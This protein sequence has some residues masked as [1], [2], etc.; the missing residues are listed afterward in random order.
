MF[1]VRKKVKMKNLFLILCSIFI[2]FIQI[3]LINA[4]VLVGNTS[5]NLAGMYGASA[6]LTGWVNLS[7][8]NRADA[9][10]E[11]VMGQNKFNSTLKQLHDEFQ[12]KYTCEPS[13]CNEV[14]SA[15]FEYTSK[16]INLSIA[17]DTYLGLYLN[18]IVERINEVSFSI[19]S[20]NQPGCKTPLSIDFAAD[21]SYDFDINKYNPNQAC[22]ISQGCF[23]SSEQLSEGV[24]TKEKYCERVYLN[25]APALFIGGNVKRIKDNVNVTMFLLS[26]KS[27]QIPGA[28]CILSNIQTGAYSNRQCLITYQ[29]N[30]PDYYYVCASD[31]NVDNPGEANY[32]IRFETNKPCGFKRDISNGFTADYDLF[33]RAAQYDSIG[34]IIVNTT[35]YNKLDFNKVEDYAMDYLIKRYNAEC[36]NG[37]VIPMKFHSES[38]NS[39]TIDRIRIDYDTTSISGLLSQK[40]NDIIKQNAKLRSNFVLV[41]LNFLNVPESAGNY[42]LTLKLDGSTFFEKDIEVGKIPMINYLTPLSDSAGIDILFDVDVDSG[43]DIVEYA[44][45]FDDNTTIEKTD[46][47]QVTHKYKKEGNYVVKIEARDDKG[48]IGK[49]EFNVIIKEPSEAVSKLIDQ[50]K[51]FINEIN[52]RSDWYIGLIKQDYEID[53]AERTITTIERDI[54]RKGNASDFVAILDTLKDLKIPVDLTSSRKKYDYSFDRGV[55]SIDNIVALTREDYDIKNREKILN[56]LE[57]WNEDNVKASISQEDFEAVFRDDKTENMGKVFKFDINVKD[58]YLIIE[59]RDV[60]FKQDYGEV[61]LQGAYGLRIKE[62]QIIEFFAD[63]VNVYL[64]PRLSRLSIKEACNDNGVCDEGESNE[65]CPSDCKKSRAWAWILLLIAII[66]AI[67]AFTPWIIR[68]FKSYQKPLFKNEFEKMNLIN[69]IKESQARG[70]D[71]NEIVD[72]LKSDGWNSRQISWGFKNVDKTQQNLHFQ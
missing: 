3:S 33:A 32:M 67:L 18:G 66:I 55:V 42:K 28:T 30:K 21:G 52:Q 48:F 59:G 57:K 13:D 2:V 46:L 1:K 9:V 68:Y 62:P 70:L 47:P 43:N 16:N 40:I 17:Q 24:I 51:S 61:D 50:Y 11:A 69:F 4:A 5:N 7:F 35:T 58:V 14:Y 31:P 25:E 64:S 71:K 38:G 63:D 12:L 6:N 29:I 8:D 10:F 44:W 34:N 45:D 60:K 20:N 65:N 15:S 72:E 36:N 56:A 49:K 54:A 39:F 27:E 26:D 53:N 22:E 23:D 37:C 19:T 41:N